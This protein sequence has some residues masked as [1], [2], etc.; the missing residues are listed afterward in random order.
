[1]CY[2]CSSLSPHKCWLLNEI[3]ESGATE[4]IELIL[5]GL[6]RSVRK[7]D[8]AIK[9]HCLFHFI[10][11]SLPAYRAPASLHGAHRCH[12]PCLT[13]GLMITEEM[14]FDS[15]CQC[16]RS[17]RNIIYSFSQI[18][19]KKRRKRGGKEIKCFLDGFFWAFTVVNYPYDQF[20]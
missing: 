20:A 17:T 3:E 1:M 8:N 4:A 16:L 6:N 10:I 13:P 11:D 12:V 15:P 14:Q 9:C 2:R 18:K 19:K 5:L 7:R